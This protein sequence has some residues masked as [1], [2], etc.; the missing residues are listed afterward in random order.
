M[1]S[2]KLLR[3]EA[4]LLLLILVSSVFIWRYIPLSQFQ[5][6]GFIYFTTSVLSFPK[7]FFVPFD[8]FARATFFT[9]PNLFDGEVFFYMMFQFAWVIL[10][11]VAFW[12]VVRFVTKSKYIALLAILFFSLSYVAKYDMFSIGGYQYFV[13]RGAILLPELVSFLFLSLYLNKPRLIG[14]YFLSLSLYLFSIFMGF[15]GTWF[16]PIFLYYPVL[17]LIFNWQ[18]VKKITRRIVWTP[19]PFLIGNLLIIKQ[20]GFIPSEPIQSFVIN[21]PLHV[22][23]GVLQQL[24]VI[25]PGLSELLK[26]NQGSSFYFETVLIFTALIYFIVTLILCKNNKDLRTLTLSVVFSLAT[27]FLFNLYLNEAN[28]LHTFGS[29]R[30]FYF[31]FTL[32]ALF[33]AMFFYL[34][35]LKKTH[36]V[37]VT[38]VLCFVWIVYNIDRIDKNLKADAP[39]QQANRETIEYAKNISVSEE[40]GLIV[41]LPA[42]IGGWGHEF[43]SRFYGNSRVK[44]YMEKSDPLDLVETANKGIDANKVYVLHYDTKIQRVVDQSGLAREEILSIQKR[45]VVE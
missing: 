2:I 32:V 17:Y 18:K 23:E 31:P 21:N 42:N 20:S 3:N 38:L 34:I 40:E 9:L 22:A 24:A 1:I 11:D 44:F 43:I 37:V 19:L 12:V 26:Y 36:Y 29:S 33:W 25:T 15:F 27:I 8:L 16:L 45:K 35:A 39:I 10:T 6:E 14:R 30:Y 28:V 41:E 7:N 13:Q 5:G 4:L